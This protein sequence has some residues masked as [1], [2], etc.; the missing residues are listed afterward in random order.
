MAASVLTNTSAMVALS[1]LRST[2]SNLE[3]VNSMIS[4]GKKVATAKD[5]AAVFAISKV[6]ESDVAGFKALNESLSLGQSTVAVA[7]NAANSIGT[8]LNEIKGK[9]ISANED[10]VDRQKLQDEIVSLRGQITSIVNSAQFNGLN[11]I[12]GDIESAG[13]TFD[14]L[15]SLNRDSS[16]G[17]TTGN[18]TFDPTNSNLSASSGTDLTTGTNPATDS[19]NFAA[20]TAAAGAN[21]ADPDGT[22]VG[23]TSEQ[24]ANISGANAFGLDAVTAGTS[25]LGAAGD[26]NAFDLS[27][28]DFLD[29]T[30]AAG[31]TQALAA[32]EVDVNGANLADALMAGD[33]ITMAVGNTTAEYTIQVGDTA[34]DVA[35]GIRGAL[36][37]AGLSTD[38]YTLD[39]TST[40]G[41]LTVTNETN[42]EVNGY[43]KI[44]R[45]GGGLAGLD[46]IDVS[47]SAG[48]ASATT[49]IEI[50]IQNAV[51]AQAALGTV[52]K[53]LDIQNE[54]TKTLIDSFKS[55]I[56]A[57]VDADLE[58]ASARL[59]SLQVQ[60]Q[61]GIQALSI[62]NQAP[63]NILALFR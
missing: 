59:Q 22:L 7:S 63:Q 36:I 16:G 30:G 26:V 33:K 5:S 4:T 24:I 8:L 47:T 54:F 18:I 21:Q 55:G 11:L 38:D 27:A 25:G 49:Q 9:I 10:N 17:V 58:E 20:R 42:S 15:A 43:Y 39:T 37:E 29:A 12:N 32:D 52:E 3:K 56:G 61:L 41:M 28:F 50:F 2:N 44:T 48:A 60:Q 35:V 23:L 62:A 40:A 31:G 14:V 19:V 45:A 57:L 53:R 13:N 46:S 34:D 6:M 51:D 1:T